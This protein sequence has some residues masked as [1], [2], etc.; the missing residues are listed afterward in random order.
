MCPADKANLLLLLKELRAGLGPDAYISMASQASEAGME[1][2]DVAAA[3]Q[4]IDSWHVMS[5]DYTVSDLTGAGAEVMSPN[6]PLY[7]PP[8]PALQKSINQTVVQYI[9]AGVPKSKIS[10]GIPFYSHTVREPPG[11][12]WLR[13]CLIFQ[14]I[15]DPPSTSLT[16][17]LLTR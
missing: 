6:A 5:Y 7:N 14:P 8:A 15:L 4:Y 3:S 1:D 10:V 17:Q 2:E 9:K 12:L 11:S 13:D 16:V